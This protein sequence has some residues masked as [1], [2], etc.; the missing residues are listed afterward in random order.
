MQVETVIIGAGQAGLSTGYHLERLGRS[1]VMLESNRRVGDTWRKRW[2][3]LRLFTPARFDGLVG[4]RFPAPENSFPTK[5]EMADYLEAYARHF[6]L[7]VLTGTRVERVWREGARYMV[8]TGD[9]L[10]E[11]DNVV[12]AMSS[13]QTGRVPEF[14]SELAPDITQMH[15]IDYRNLAQLKDGP[16][17]VVGAGNSGAEVA[18]EAARAG[19]TTYFSGRVTGEIPFRIEGTASRL[20]LARFVFRFVFHRVLTIDTPIGRSA[21]RKMFSMGTPLIRTR[22]RDLV[23][24]GVTRVPRVEGVKRGQPLL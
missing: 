15:S 10:F 4:L 17:L 13:Y 6:D 3:S 2:D 16:V 11:A 20:G 1:Y 23:E 8:S 21:R 9:Q 24:A 12:I 5:D 7:S 19:R 14:A 18:I 22:E